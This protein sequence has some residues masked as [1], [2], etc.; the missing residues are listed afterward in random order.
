M[1]YTWRWTT[2]GQFSVASAYEWQFTRAM[3]TFH[4]ED[5]RKAKAEPKC[6]FFSWLVM[7]D[8][9]LTTDNMVKKNWQC[10]PTCAFCFCQHETTTHLLTECN[11]TEA[12]WRKL[13]SDFN[14]PGFDQLNSLEGPVQWVRQI[15]SSSQKNERRKKVGWLFMFWW[16]IWKERNRKI[17]DNKEIRPTASG[18]SS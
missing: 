18:P 6:R 5:I 13:A 7:Q 15:L 12:C 2:S 1:L 11:Y 8:K 10:E 4:A 17:F 16:H 14:L 9:A 3:I